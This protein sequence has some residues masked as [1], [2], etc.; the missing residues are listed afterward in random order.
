M[1]TR[2]AKTTVEG[3]IFSKMKAI[4]FLNILDY[5]MFF[6]CPIQTQPKSTTEKTK[7]QESTWSSH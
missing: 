7:Q 6:K 5:K 3:P 1:A 2:S 4:Q